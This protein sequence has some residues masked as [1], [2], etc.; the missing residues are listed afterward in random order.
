MIV[1]S[2][3]QLFSFSVRL[4]SFCC[5]QKHLKRKPNTLLHISLQTVPKFWAAYR[6]LQHNRGNN[7]LSCGCSYWSTSRYDRSLALV[8]CA[9]RRG[10]VSLCGNNW[11]R[12]RN[13]HKIALH[14]DR[15]PV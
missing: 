7:L 5:K 13:S 4:C 6:A 14:Q 11:D 12:S 8:I 15:N 1:N 10:S 9:M 2:R 3:R